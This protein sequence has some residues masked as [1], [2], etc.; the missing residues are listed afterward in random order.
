LGKA[1]Q[2]QAQVE[3]SLSVV[4]IAV[5]VNL[6]SGLSDGVDR[7][8]AHLERVAQ[9][10]EDGPLLF[11]RLTLFE[12][13]P[14]EKESAHGLEEAGTFTLKLANKRERERMTLL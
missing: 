6:N 1:H 13:V 8:V 12:E 5:E 11:Q 9:Q 7:R 2:V 14:S 4:R 10:P 3:E